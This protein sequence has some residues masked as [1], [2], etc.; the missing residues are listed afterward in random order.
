[1]TFDLLERVSSG[2]LS[3]FE[4]VDKDDKY[5]LP[6]LYAIPEI[7]S[8]SELEQH[9]SHLDP[10]WLVNRA[11]QVEQQTGNIDD[12]LTLLSLSD[13]VAAKQL[14]RDMTCFKHVLQYF[15]ERGLLS[16]KLTFSRMAGEV[17]RLPVQEKRRLVIYLSEHEQCHL[18]LLSDAFASTGCENYAACQ[19]MDE[20][21]G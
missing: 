3:V 2:D 19:L 15:D 20:I 9:V 13:H 8:A 6:L 5:Y 21:F 18:P 7:I 1:M 16:R 10:V 12:A 11:I 17:S 14:H 4:Q